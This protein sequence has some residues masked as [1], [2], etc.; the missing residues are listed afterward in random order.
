M[1][2]FTAV[3]SLSFLIIFVTGT[4]DA[5]DD[6]TRQS[7][8]L[9][10]LVGENSS[11]K[12]KAP[13]SGKLTIQGLDSL[14]N[15][16]VFFVVVYFSGA[17]VDR[18]QVNDTGY[19]Y[20]PGV[21]R[22]SAIIAVEMD[23]IEVG[24][25]QLPSSVMGNIRQDIVIPWAL[26][27]NTKAKNEV[28]SAK[29]F[30]SRT[31]ENERLFEKAVFLAKDKKTD[32]AIKL[33]SQI[34][35]NDSKD[36]AAWT[37]LGTLF[38]N[39]KNFSEA[40]ESYNKALTQKPEFMLALLNLG[41]LFLAQKQPDKAIPVLSKA[42]ETDAGSADAQ[43]YLGEAYLQA[44]KG[45]KAVIYLNE[46]IKLAPFEKAE[47]HLRIASLY[48]GAGLK[49]KAA[50]EYKMFLQKNSNYKDK[51]MIEKYIKENSPE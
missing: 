6:E 45:S 5:Q 46:A 25:Y 9:P 31:K 12:S 18:R 24:R 29:N 43:H 33:F 40:E 26:I 51:E 3:L 37:E 48:N 39:N 35:K 22:E 4:A 28:I 36:F 23:G 38:F 44:K 11:N 34:L 19:Y 13:L 15:K 32:D 2:T 8:G 7:S 1:K 49:D 10:M 27:Q 30:Y 21:P 50:A 17:L 16:P 42:V 47:I 14:Q 20:I 41:K